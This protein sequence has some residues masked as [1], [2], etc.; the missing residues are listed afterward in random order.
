MTAVRG[1]AVLGQLLPSEAAAAAVRIGDLVA[2]PKAADGRSYGLVHALHEGRRSDDAATIEVHL[3]GEL[4]AAGGARRFRRGVSACPPLGAGIRR[5]ARAEAAL[6]YAEP[7]APHVRVGGLR[8]D[9]ELPAH[10][11]TDALL[12]GTSRSSAARARASPAP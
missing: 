11:V 5:A 12:A 10:L 2:M 4:A 3:L 9:P 7:E 1:A 6:V 8:Q